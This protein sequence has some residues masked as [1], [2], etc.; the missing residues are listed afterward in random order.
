VTDAPPTELAARARDYEAA[1][2]TAILPYW[3]RTAVDPRYGGYRL[4][5]YGSPR[6]ARFHRWRARQ[7][8][9]KHLVGQTRTLWTFVHAHRAGIDTGSANLDAARSGVDFLLEHFHDHEH[10]GWRWETTREGQPIDER[11]SLLGQ[12]MVVLA[13]VE[14]ARATNDV[15]VIEHARETYD[16]IEAHLRDTTNGGW[17]ESTTR[18]WQ[19]L[20]PN[21][22]WMVGSIGVKSGN[23]YLHM[24]EA[25]AEL[26]DFT[27]DPDVEQSLAESIDL[28]RGHFF[29]DD[30]RGWV[31]EL[32]LDWS[33]VEHPS[34]AFSYGHAVEFAWLLL[35]AE[36]VLGRAPST[37]YLLGVVDHALR[38]SWDAANGGLYCA[39]P[40]DAPATDTDK[41]W[42]AQA[43]MM[44][45][46]TDAALARPGDRYE[47]DLV[48]LIDFV[49]AHFADPRDGVW[50]DAV[51]REGTVLKRGK[52]HDWIGGYHDTRALVKLC[53]AFGQL[54]ART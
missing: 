49:N 39:G 31:H 17:I 27:H 28:T 23:V 24:M 6:L 19:T 52:A 22:E 8:A 12:F 30:P 43:E 10:G 7:H 1:L 40:V 29:P 2:R 44:A 26:A 15:T 13:F 42:W 16:V 38:Y 18:D 45:A 36:Q 21:G 9:S 46:L 32:S 35:H 11:K 51:S 5:D 41:Y 34:P 20:D 14:Y 3:R 47:T 25:L 4:R 37:D 48:Q 53:R 50:I 33:P 54:D